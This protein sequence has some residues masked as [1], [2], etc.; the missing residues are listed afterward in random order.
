ML[1]Q[2]TELFQLLKVKLCPLLPNSYVEALSPRT[3]ECEEKA[4]V[5][6]GQLFAKE[7]RQVI[8]DPVDYLSRSQGGPVGD[9]LSDDLDPHEL[10]GKGFG[11]FVPAETLS[12]WLERDRMK[13]RENDSEG[14]SEAGSS[15][16]EC[17]AVAHGQGR[18]ATALSWCILG[19]EH[20]AN[21]DY[22]Q[23][24]KSSGICLA[25]FQTWLGTMTPFYPAISFS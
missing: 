16:L 7:I 8:V 12:A 10:R 14:I 22:S 15:V 24:L 17:R 21:G 1:N 18:R 3:S 5:M 13:W 11:N 23:A 20:A 6:A 9:T 2:S 4:R 25:G 19:T